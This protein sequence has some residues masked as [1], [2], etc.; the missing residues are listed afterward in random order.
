MTRSLV[1]LAAALAVLAGGPMTLAASDPPAA[2]EAALPTHPAQLAPMST[3]GPFPRF[4]PD[5]LASAG[6]PDHKHVFSYP[7]Y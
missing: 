3:D 7:G 1:G 2:V 6:Y 5:E 4:T